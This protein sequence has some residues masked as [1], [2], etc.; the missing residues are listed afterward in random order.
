MQFKPRPHGL[1]GL[2]SEFG[3]GGCFTSGSAEE[4]SIRLPG[5]A[6]QPQL[7]SSRDDYP[8]SSLLALLVH[9]VVP[10]CFP[11]GKLL[12]RQTKADPKCNLWCQ[13]PSKSSNKIE[14]RAFSCDWKGRPRISA[15]VRGH[16]PTP[17]HRPM[18]QMRQ[19]CLVGFGTPYLSSL[20]TGLGS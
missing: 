19:A 2:I 7:V 3:D 4:V 12:F 5:H 10:H 13:H 16:A 8:P 1:H 14:L 17:D 18:P 20:Q 9:F 6:R 11:Q 15:Q